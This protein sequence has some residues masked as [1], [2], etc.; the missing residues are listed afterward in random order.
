MWQ[1]PVTSGG[2]WEAGAI[3]G[4]GGGT[5]ECWRVKA[6]YVSLH[7]HTHKTGQ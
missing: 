6:N 7:T 4:S 2:T 1:A 5:R 3:P